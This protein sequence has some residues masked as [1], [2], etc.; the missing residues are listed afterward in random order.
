MILSETDACPFCSLPNK[1]WADVP[2]TLQVNGY[3]ELNQ[4]L[5]YTSKNF[6]VKPDVSPLTKNHFLIIPVTH[7][8]SS[9]SVAAEEQ[10]ELTNIKTKIKNFYKTQMGKDCLF[11]E[12]GS[13]NTE[14]SACIHHAHIHSVPM[15]KAEQEHVSAYALRSLGNPVTTSQININNYLNLE[16][17]DSKTLYW[18]DKK[19]ESQIFRKIISDVLGYS[20]RANWQACI[21]YPEEREISHK[22]LIESLTVKL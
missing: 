10:L 18:N 12:H 20:S 8:F 14:G 16:T 6:N 1:I 22:W 17:S 19:R 15:D 3:K 5:I 4:K 11:F 2:L 13:C 9:L 21:L 7:Y